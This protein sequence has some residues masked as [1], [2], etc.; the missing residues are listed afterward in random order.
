MSE[1]L[2][3]T[4]VMFD[5]V[6]PD[7]EKIHIG[8]IAH[9]LSMLCRANGHFPTFYSVGQH[10]INCMQEAAARGYSRQVQLASLLHDASEAYLADVTRPVKKE[11]PRYLEIEAPLQETIWEKFLG[12]LLTKEENAQV[13][14]VDDAIL[15]YE[16]LHLMDMALTPEPPELISTPI[17]TFPGFEQTEE[18]FLRWFRELSC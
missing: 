7:P 15:Y 16:F 14:A 13:F 17:I 6:H 10:S 11:L 2:T 3:H 8:D 18:E 1:I 9:A 12:R 4:R 5:P